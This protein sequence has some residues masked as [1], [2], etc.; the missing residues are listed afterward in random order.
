MGVEKF[1]IIGSNNTGKTTFGHRLTADLLEL[2][3]K[4]E[5]IDETIQHSPFPTKSGATVEAQLWFFYTQMA[6]ELAYGRRNDKLVCDKSALDSLCYGKWAMTR[7]N[8]TAT[9]H[10]LRELER[11]VGLEIGSYGI[12]LLIPIVGSFPC[13]VWTPGHDHQEQI[14]T[15]V[16][17]TLD[18][19]SAPYVEIESVSA[20][21]RSREAQEIL[22]S[23]GLLT[24]GQKTK[25]LYDS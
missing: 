13:P 1:A 15:I 8:S 3:H 7:D 23:R 2:R 10:Q 9:Q 16:R 17:S 19:F 11:R 12:H 4:A 18:E 22:K 14:D 25:A 5:M 24:F 20:E 21:N 6:R